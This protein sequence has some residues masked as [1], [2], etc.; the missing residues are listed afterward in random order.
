MEFPQALFDQPTVRA[1]RWQ[2]I[3]SEEEERAREG[4]QISTHFRFPAGLPARDLTL[5]DC[6]ETD[7]LLEV[8]Y[9]SQAEIWRINHG[10]RRSGD[11]N[12]F[13]VDANTGA[14]QRQIDEDE[15]PDGTT[16]RSV[17]RQIRPYA[18]D[19]RNLLLLR[20]AA[21]QPDEDFLRTLAYSLRRAIRLDYQVEEQ[22]IQV[23]LIGT[24]QQRRIILWEAAE[25]GIGVWEQLI[26]ERDAFPKLARTV[27]NLLHFDSVTGN[28]MPSWAERCPAACYDCLLRYANQLDHR[29]LDRHHVRYFLMR[30]ARSDPIRPGRRSYDEQYAW[31]RERIDPASSFE[32]SFLDHLYE[33]KL[34][35]PDFAQ[36]TPVADVFLQPD[37]YYERG[38]SPGVCVFIDGPHHTVHKTEDSDA[39][40]A[41]EDR[42][43]RVI[44][45]RADRSLAEQI[46]ANPD[47][48]SSAANGH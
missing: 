48:F 28:E 16:P 18:S 46:K 17:R 40:E 33:R 32:R 7:P 19:T 42:G 26:E 8:R 1:T 38:T 3:S 27:L 29:H 39:R 34:R 14:W 31:L 2:R 10:W 23:E 4:Y 22:E 47:I 30:L 41:L 36:H 12:G 44:A 5:S 20:A 15:E 45:I 9:V 6:E 43:Y 37:F 13:L 21:D 35:L 11:H 25:G 24:N